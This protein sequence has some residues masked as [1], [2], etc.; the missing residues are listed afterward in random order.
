MAALATLQFY[1][2]LRI[3]EAAALDWADVHFAS[4][5]RRSR[6]TFTRHVLYLRSKDR[7]DKVEPG[8][9]NSDGGDGTKEHP[10][11][12]AVFQELRRLQQ[13]G[14]ET[15]LVFRDPESGSFWPY[16]AVQYRFNR[17]F[18]KAGMPYTSTHVM[19]HGGTRKSFD[20]SSGD[21]G[22]AQQLLGNRDRKTVDLYAQRSAQALTRYVDGQWDRITR[23]QSVHPEGSVVKIRRDDE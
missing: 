13:R 14:G 4:D 20:D 22:V 15:G 5:P 17:A 1:H 10:M 11:M 12:P 23:A 6:L 19:R 21:I 9:K 8:F 18:E 16:R 2:G 7:Q 3:S